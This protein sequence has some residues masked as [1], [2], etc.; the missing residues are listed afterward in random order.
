MEACASFGGPSAR[1]EGLEQ[2]LEPIE[3]EVRILRVCREGFGVSSLMAVCLVGPEVRAAAGQVLTL[4]E[5]SGDTTLLVTPS[6]ATTATPMRPSG[7]GA[8]AI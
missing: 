1:L 8:S 7:I 2:E 3:S 5:F 4:G 6:L